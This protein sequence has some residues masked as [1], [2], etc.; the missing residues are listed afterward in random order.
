MDGNAKASTW[1]KKRKGESG[2]DGKPGARNTV[3]RVKRV[4]PVGRER[5]TSDERRSCARAM[6][7]AARWE[8]GQAGMYGTVGLVILLGTKGCKCTEWKQDEMARGLR[9]TD[10]KKKKK[11]ATAETGVLL[12]EADSSE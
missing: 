8:Y 12:P 4:T 9:A 11:G 2:G 10:K 1:K 5:A 6:L 3:A 7:R